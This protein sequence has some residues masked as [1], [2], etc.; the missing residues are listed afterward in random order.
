MSSLALLQRLIATPSTSRDEA[1]TAR[2]LYDYLTEAGIAAQ[3]YYNNVWAV[4]ANYD[5][6]KPTL[7]L[8][9]HHDTVKPS[10]AYTRDPYAPT[11]EDGR[12]YGLGSNDAGGAMVSLVELF[13]RHY[14]DALPFNLLLDISAAEEC[15]G[16]QGFRAMLP[17]LTRLGYQIDMALVGEP[18]GMKAAVGERGLVVLDCVAH[19]LQGHAAR[20]E[21]VN[22][23]YKA[24][25]D[26]ETLRTFQFE[27]TSPLL[28]PIKITTTQIEAGTQHNVV[29]ESCKYV[30][31]IRT[32]DAYTNQEVVDILRQH[33]D[34]DA[35]PR[36]TR[37]HASA[38]SDA[39]PLVKAAQAI[40]LETFV[41]PTT[42]E[43][44]LMP[45][46]SLKLGP[47]ESSRSHKA[48]EYILLSELDDGAR[49]YEAFI[50]AL[51]TILI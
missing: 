51:K 10:A 22:A 24:V 26:I 32:T 40:G 36:S 6:A 38:I 41:S 12:L 31:D 50:H 30:V 7:L 11:I 27:K 5:K 14:R 25:R 4:S 9:S 21:G 37:V 34:S 18:T 39:H 19:G 45:F 23:I 16:E 49:T 15:M 47:G 13:I 8:S 42:S 1:A 17:E 43:M 48:D 2:I 44:A 29:P 20:N 35:T 3:L 28:G 33:I 46:P